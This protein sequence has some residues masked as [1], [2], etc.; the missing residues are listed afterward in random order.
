[1]AACAYL[2]HYEFRL[3][4]EALMEREV[5]WA[6]AR[7]SSARCASCCRT[8]RAAPGLAAAPRPV[9]LRPSRRAQIAAGDAHAR[10]RPR[11]GRGKPL[12]E[13]YHRAF[14]YSDCW[15]ED[16]KYVVSNFNTGA[17]TLTSN[18]P[19]TG[20]TLQVPLTRYSLFANTRYTVNDFAEAYVQA[21]FDE[22]KTEHAPR[23]LRSGR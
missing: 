19:T 18:V 16:A 22:N 1:M 3:V 20:G 13:G 11:R 2:E 23:R 10:P 8:T 15:V 7:A 9:P 17:R 6:I 14:E 12:R 21:R 4:R 5:L